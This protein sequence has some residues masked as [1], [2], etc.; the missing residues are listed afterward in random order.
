MK[1]T[2]KFKDLHHQNDIMFLGNVHDLLSALILE[3][4]G[5]K[6]IA[7][8]SWG[9]ANTFGYSDG[10]KIS[11]DQLCNTV[12]KIVEHVNIPLSVDI[13]SGYGASDSEIRHNVLRLADMGVAGINLEDS[14][15]NIEGLKDIKQQQ[16]TIEIIKSS[17]EKHGH[18]NFFIN[19]RTDTYLSNY[20]NPIDETLKRC[21]AYEN[22]G[23]DGI[24]VPGITDHDDIQKLVISTQLPV[25][26]MSLPGCTDITELQN[27]GVKRFSFGNAL[28]DKIISNLE[29]YADTMIKTGNTEKLYQHEPIKLNFE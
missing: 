25:N 8:T 19:A 12:Y 27:L 16:Q 11:F 2:S 3:S 23:A 18:K 28:S 21:N 5:F 10:E 29:S 1:M 22:C 7:T 15:H 14:Q 13:E 24:F 4:A 17:L 26:V 9:V 6:A 20:D